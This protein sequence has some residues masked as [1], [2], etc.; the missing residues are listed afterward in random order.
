MSHDDIERRQLPLPEN[1]NF[2]TSRHVGGDESTWQDRRAA[3]ERTSKNY[4]KDAPSKSERVKHFRRPQARSREYYD[5]LQPNMAPGMT[6]W[7]T[8]GHRRIAKDL[9]HPGHPA[10]RDPQPYQDIDVEDTALALQEAYAGEILRSAPWGWADAATQTPGSI[11]RKKGKTRVTEGTVTRKAQ[12]RT[13]ARRAAAEA[14]LKEI[15]LRCR[16]GIV[17]GPSAGFREYFHDFVVPRAT[18]VADYFQDASEGRESEYM[19]AATAYTMGDLRRSR[20]DHHSV[21]VQRTRFDPRVFQAAALLA[22]GLMSERENAM[23]DPVVQSEHAQVQTA[24]M[25]RKSAT[26][27][28]GNP[29]QKPTTKKKTASAQPLGLNSQG[30]RSWAST[31][32]PS[33]SAYGSAASS[34]VYGSAASNAGQKRIRRKKH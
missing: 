5:Q 17:Y 3:R 15:E 33:S 25:R 10:F 6:T 21:A 22:G 29:R 32:T 9:Q 14:D 16:Y 4:K 1:L 30:K 23:W 18:D 2:T 31:D 26:A 28:R 11:Y 7:V 8:R 34:S 24:P 20:T 19:D 27:I 13:N 12:T